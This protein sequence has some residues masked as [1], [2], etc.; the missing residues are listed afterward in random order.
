[1]P[2]Y[3]PPFARRTW[4]SYCVWIDPIAAVERTELMRRLLADGIAS[5][6]GVM[7]IHAEP[8]YAGAPHAPLPHTENVAAGTMMLPLFPDMTEAQQDWV[9]DRL[10]T[11]AGALAA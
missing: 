6:R 3:D 11:H 8:A 10:A 5:R 2:P 7:A 1:R 4:Q 9:V